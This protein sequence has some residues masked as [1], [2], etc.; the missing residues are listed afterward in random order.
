MRSEFKPRTITCRN[1]RGEL[2]SEP[3]EVTKVWKDYFQDLLEGR[4]EPIVLQNVHTE[5]DI[6]ADEE[7]PPP[8]ITEVDEPEL[9]NALHEIMVKIWET[10]KIP[11]DWEEG[12]VCPI[13][14]KGDQLECRNYREITLLNTAYK[15][16]S[17]LL[18]ARLQS[19]TDEVIGNYQ[20]GFRP[21]RSTIYQIHTL[22]QIL[23]KTKEYNIKTFHLF[24]DFKAAYGSINRDKMIE[25]E[26]EF[27]D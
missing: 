26:T 6:M 5:Q 3:H 2:V 19:Y 24:V 27:G 1:K 9:V 12:S 22:R 18:F 15:I 21:Q 20:C 23:E 14:K 25:V 10:E 4:V 11:I 17:N 16:F 8:S 13:F 7:N